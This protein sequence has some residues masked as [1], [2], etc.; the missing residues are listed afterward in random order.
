LS[1]PSSRPSPVVPALASA[2]PLFEPIAII[3]RACVLPG[4]LSPEELWE[5]VVA[6]NDVLTTV[7]AGRWGMEAHDVL[8]SGASC[9]DR[10]WTDRGGYVHGFEQRFDPRGF[11]VAAEEVER[12]DPLFQWLLHTAR[13]ALRDAGHESSDARIGAVFGNLSFPSASM[14]RFAESV[15]MSAHTDGAD[16]AF[17]VPGRPRPDPRNRFNSGLPA[18]I[19][20]R[21]LALEAGAF[22]LDAA[23][24][25]SLYAIKIGCD[26]LHDGR[27]DLVLAGAVNCADDLFIHV[28]FSALSALSKTGRSR[29]FHRAADGLVPAE[30]AGFVVL[31]RL[32]DARRGGDNILGIIRGVGL[33]NDGRGQGTLVPSTEGQVRAIRAAYE[34]SGLSPR[35]ISLLECHATGTAI[36]DTT[37]IESLVE[38]FGTLPEP[39][40]IGSLKSNL[41]HL[42]TA[43]GV[44]GL[45]KILEGMRTGIRPPNLH[46]DEP[47]AALDGTSFRV[48]DQP[49][50]WQVP[51]HVGDGVRRA[52]LSAFGFGGNNAHMIVEQ[53]D[54]SRLGDETPITAG[55]NVA[56]RAEASPVAIVGVGV[57]AAGCPDRAAFCEA[58]LSGASC[59][60]EDADG[61]WEGRI[62]WLDVDIA[63]LG[64]PPNDLRQTLPQQLLVLDAGRQAAAEV[65]ALPRERTGIYVGMGTDPEVARY[66]ARW[67][68]AEW[69]AVSGNPADA[70]GPDPD[71]LDDARDGVIGVLE[72]AGVI[73]TMPNIVANRLNRQLDL[74]G[75]SCTVSLEE[76]SG[77]QALDLAVRAL[78]SRELDAALVGAVDLSCEPVHLEAA[79]ECLNPELRVPGDAAVA[80]VLKRL[81]DAVRDGDR[82]YAIMQGDERGEEE[83]EESGG[84]KGEARRRANQ[85][86][87]W[88]P[89]SEIGCLTERFGHA[90]AAS[91]LFHLVG[92]ALSIHHRVLPNG[93]PWLSGVE[94][95]ASVAIAAMD[96]LQSNAAR[97]QL[98]EHFA[99]V[100]RPERAA[101]ILQVFEGRDAGEVLNALEAGRTSTPWNDDD[102]VARARLVVVADDEPTLLRR[103][104][105]ARAHIRD[106]APPGEG[107]HFRAEPV[108]GDLAFVFTSAGSAYHGMGGDL[109]AA[110]PELGD[111]LACRFDGLVDAMGWVFG[112]P[113][114][115]PTNDQR[116]WG[117]SCLSQMHAELTR[118]L[119]GLEPD[120]AI[121]YSSGESNSLFAL[122]A[123]TDMDAMRREIDESGLFTTELAGRF[124]AI[125][126][127]W[128]VG[129]SDSPEW[130][131]W[132][133]LAPVARVSELIADESRV[134]LAI[135]HTPSDCVIAGDSNSCHRVVEAVTRSH[136]PG[137]CR[138][139]EYNMAAHVPEV[140]WFRD[141]WLRIHRRKVTPVPGVRFYSGGSEAAYIPDSESCTQTIMNQAHQTLDFSKVIERAWADGIRVFVEHGPMSACSG[142]I[143]DVLGERASEAAIVSLD[144]KGRGIE[145][146][147]DALAAL[148]AAGVV[149]DPTQL[150]DRLAPVSR[151]PEQS[152]V[153][154]A[155]RA[156]LRLPMHRE[157]VCFRSHRPARSIVTSTTR[158]G[159]SAAETS[160]SS[161]SDGV[162]I[163]RAA[164]TLPSVIDADWAAPRPAVSPAPGFA[165]PSGP[166][167]VPAGDRDPAIGVWQQ[168]VEQLSRIHQQFVAQQAQ[169]HQRFLAL[170]G[171]M[172]RAA[173][174]L[175]DAA[176]ITLPFGRESLEEESSQ[177]R[178]FGIQP[179]VVRETP[180]PSPAPGSAVES[181][182]STTSDCNDLRPSGLHLDR[183]QL[184]IHAGGRISEIFGPIFDQQD[185]Y[186]R[187]VRM[188]EPPLLLAD[189]VTGIDAEPGV[190]GTGVIWT[191]TDVREDSWYLHRGRMPAG[192][193][194]ESGQADLML[195]SYMGAD[196]IN[197]GDRVYRLLGCELTYEGDLPKPGETLCYEIHV[198]GHA[199]QDEI[200]LFFFHYE[201]RVEGQ[202]RIRVT[203]GQAGFFSDEELANSEGI[204]W[205]A[206]AFE[207][208][209]DPRL[210]APT[211]RCTRSSFDA[212]RLRAFAHGRPWE[213]FGAGFELSRTHTATPTIQTG[214]MLLLDTVSEFDPS[215]GPWG[216]GYLRAETAVH[217]DDWFFDGHFK[218]DPCMPGTLMFEGC[219]QAMAF[220]LAGLGFTLERDAWRFEPLTGESIAL[221]CRGQVTPASKHLVYELFIEEVIDGPEP[222]LYADLLCTVDGRK[223]FHARRAGLKLVPDW[224]LSTRPELQP[225][226]PAVEPTTVASVATADGGRFRFDEKSILACAWGRPSDAFGPMYERF[227]APGRV[228][229]LPGPPYLFVSRV[230][231]ISGEIGG[232]EVG[233]TVEIEYDIPADAWYFAENGAPTMPYAV[234]LEAALQP[235]GWLASYIGSA[236]TVD[237][238]VCFR[239]L[240][241]TAIQHAELFDGAG[242]LRTKVE[243]TNIS[244]SAGMI[245]VSFDVA[246]HVS[247]TD[248]ESHTDPPSRG[249]ERRVY[250]MN[251]VFGF[252]PPESLSLENQVGQPTTD[253]QRALL[254]AESDFEVDLRDEPAR[255][256]GGSLRLGV[257]KLRTLDCVTGYWP[258]GGSEGLGRVRAQRS[259]DADDW[260]FKAHFFQDP[261]QPGSLGIEAMIQTLQFFMLE[262][263]MGEAAGIDSPRFEPI[264]IDR[265]MTW[266]YRGQ[267]VPSND[268]VAVTLDVTEVGHDER[269]PFA[270]ASAS[271]WCD[272]IR[273]Y[274]A[275]GM[276]MRIVAGDAPIAG[277]KN[278]SEQTLDP[279]VD[280]WLADHCPTWNRPA[281]PM[282]CIADQLARSVTGQ[283]VAL[284]DVQVKGFVDFEGPRRLWTEVEPR[285]ADVSFVRLFASGP[286]RGP[287]AANATI[288][289]ASAL[290]ETGRYAEPPIALDAEH[291]EQI[292]DP[293]AAGKLFHGPAFQLMTRCEITDHGAS[294]QLD[295]GAGSVP[296]GSLPAALLDAAL[297]GIP[298]DELHRWAPEI[299]DDKVGYPARIV[300]LRLHGEIPST[301][302]VRCEI[303]FDGYLVS[304]DLP[305]FRIQLI[306]DA[307][308]FVQ[309]VLIEACFAKGALGSAPPLDRRAFLRN[310]EFVEGVSLSRH[311][312][313]Q[314]RLS[315]ADVDASDWMPGTIEGI[316]GTRDV[317]QIAVKEHLAARERL[318][319]GR[320]P[321]ALPLNHRAVVVSRDADGV[322]VRD[323]PGFDSASAPNS[324]FDPR[325]RS[326]DLEPLR[327]FW[328]PLLSVS[329][330]WL[331]QDLWEGLIQ[332]YVERVV[333]EDPAAF[334]ALR[335]RG[336][337]FVGNHQVQIE[338]LLIT[339]ILSALIDTPVVTM[340]NAKHEQ[341]WIGWI[342]RTLASYPGCRDS[343]SVLY[344]DQSKPDSMF[345]ILADLKPDLASGRRAFFVHPQGTRSQTSG[346][347]V[348]R[349]SSLFI[350]L[351][352]ELELPIVPVRFAGGLPVEPVSGKLEFPIGHAAQHYT[353]GAPI[354][355]DALRD[356]AYVERG[357]HVLSAMNALGKRHASEQPNPSD[358]A[359]SALVGQWE[360]QTGASEIEATFLRILQEIENP[361][362]EAQQL[363]DGARQGVLRVGGDP[364]S[365]WLAEFAKRLY[366]STGPR[367]EIGT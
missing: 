6:G 261:V 24:A 32:A 78:R 218:N 215:G 282:M 118:G 144:R 169:V 354:P 315:A 224:P 44:A 102:P 94:R 313:G 21:A 163:M 60:K 286:D 2:Q 331:G 145:T 33:S 23:C 171:G 142:W 200:R 211:V 54:S 257:G 68:L 134:H 180:P 258:Q 249:A 107:V 243:L 89:G 15:W 154:P 1:P 247:D 344:F 335:G 166:A 314:T 143:R 165:G 232:M 329:S 352:L 263:G 112:D 186:R 184:E 116:L 238:E 117:A 336:A 290:V 287:G 348:T 338:S 208:L 7:P 217:P 41:G 95:S 296:I 49:E 279:A 133:L 248:S 230:T 216:R 26:W 22:A 278:R 220:Y 28:G 325:R 84:G 252:F 219:L 59:L 363:I 209:A 320:L 137:R 306:G 301:G 350:D 88:G 101:P 260:Y 104:E 172:A 289:V 38:T 167:S 330:H 192:I 367:V 71:W 97:W 65:A 108:S 147:F 48:L 319:P 197:K 64:I 57:V 67:R 295:A 70:E 20:E 74:G 239:N 149:V 270:I 362:P 56:R 45:I 16:H 177:Q 322:V 39:V 310:H 210:D 58:L 226:E 103:C 198:D 288:E 356:L 35:D 80:V 139:L 309:L 5:L 181:V 126:R 51:P 190:H 265:P 40:G 127:A 91:G 326:L 83:V 114:R 62:D 8:A 299:G 119:L 201:C 275:D 37:E 266:K 111:R 36:G 155:K 156:T 221:R 136:G 246:C 264:A 231:Q 176:P 195:I 244:K 120:A 241:G 72:S 52:A 174:S 178:S 121:G 110:L 53:A 168:Q 340:A 358:P 106:G 347:P 69:G 164:P 202:L 353:I 245:I 125:A 199:Q 140:D 98:S 276:G 183:A 291:G 225:G 14:S 61:Q 173:Q 194:I 223:A 179:A 152:C 146:V 307:G 18:L 269:G 274:S 294:T 123:W 153:Q 273:I 148:I 262:S 17:C 280:G 342:L 251:T 297:H 234:L 298:H 196:F 212:D 256:Y 92:A 162:Q 341:R 115:V 131:V 96:G 253:E 3:G 204:L 182:P 349:I 293:Y 93:R 305:R 188:P 90:H 292:A 250:S 9:A 364:K 259:I 317:E 333:V 138:K 189:R 135:V 75:P 50:P 130:A 46:A 141:A 175:Q 346:D 63:A 272:G 360:Q 185:H 203:G 43:A 157:P 339:N 337:I 160:S 99:S 19:L 42:V 255:Y 345:E 159:S 334:A 151:L 359:F 187:Q 236:L 77:L 76:R 170:R 100:P 158:S 267:V 109:L 228:P 271:L 327:R 312:D 124:D 12:L 105:R 254:T 233:S 206:E 235:C 284:R 316:Y 66:G 34:M 222:T 55:P 82:I 343:E 207:P 304:P 303:R 128:G 86:V 283:V 357:R 79:R 355:P 240:D 161:P 10:T 332:R 351:A 227:D 366:G 229:R 361:G 323:E 4:A 25:S 302:E 30:G 237:D 213:C 328:N 268:T 87:Q 193:M 27:A 73:G 300:E 47:I 31:R 242:T 365:I 281:L 150:L 122:G 318:H 85:T 277:L 129:E 324:T 308:V 81:D 29:P 113:D 214:K 321:E 285:T 311:V 132:A 11:A 205:S 191:E 13:E